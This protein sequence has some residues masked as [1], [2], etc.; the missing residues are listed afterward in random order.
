MRFFIEV[1]R[2]LNLNGFC[3]VWNFFKI[4]GVKKFVVRNKLY[5]LS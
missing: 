3:I 4:I 1:Y 5:I 2:F